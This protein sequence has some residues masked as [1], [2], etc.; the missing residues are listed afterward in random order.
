MEEDFPNIEETL[1]HGSLDHSIIL[2]R[3]G[4][5]EADEAEVGLLPSV[6]QLVP[7]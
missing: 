7:L 4:A 1:D 2:G 3:E 5:T 6:H